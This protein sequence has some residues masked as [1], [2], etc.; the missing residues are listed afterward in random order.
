MVGP[1]A[2][3]LEVLWDG[4]LAEPW[5]VQKVDSMVDVKAYGKAVK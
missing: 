4:Y 1:K 5:V 2:V 3:V